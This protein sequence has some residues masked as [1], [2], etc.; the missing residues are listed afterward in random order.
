MLGIEISKDKVMD[1][2]GIDEPAFEEIISE[3]KEN[4][5]NKIANKRKNVVQ[6]DKRHTQKA[7]TI[8][9]TNPSNEKAKKTLGIGD[10][11]LVEAEIEKIAKYEESMERKRQFS[12][13]IRKQAGKALK[14][15]GFD[16]SKSKLM[17]ILGI[18]DE[19]IELIQRENEQ[20]REEMILRQRN[21]IIAL[22]KKGNKKALNV[23][24]YDISEEKLQKKFGEKDF[25][26]SQNPSFL[27]A[28]NGC[29]K[30]SAILI[31]LIF[32][33]YIVYSLW[34]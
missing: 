23:L 7:L 12:V 15:L 30:T 28:H 31:F 29:D 2:L 5:E 1:R 16:P 25:K 18:S 19:E 14:I 3:M 17:K 26:K 4:T 22:N 9:G 20:K 21:R 24:G 32:S 10:E 13:V 8:L 34:H 27:G 6:T 11:E 33:F